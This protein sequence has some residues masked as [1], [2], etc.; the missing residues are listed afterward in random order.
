[1]DQ[2]KYQIAVGTLRCGDKVPSVRQLAN[3]LAV[4]QNTVL[5]VYTQLCQEKIL[6]VD[7]G[8]GTFVAT[9]PQTMPVAERE[10]IAGKLLG[11][12]AVQAIHLDVT[13]K[14]LHELLDEEYQSITRER[15][16][17]DEMR[18]EP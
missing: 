1:M 5:K 15:A 11:E 8:S 18:N 12:A 9:E 13:V 3:Q 14:R 6:S 2:I 7:R 17:G 4:N 16:G 10:Q